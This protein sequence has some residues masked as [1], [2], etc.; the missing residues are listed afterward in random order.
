M[1]SQLARSTGSL[2]ASEAALRETMPLTCEICDNSRYLAS[3]MHCKHTLKMCQG[4]NQT[5]AIHNT[6]DSC[7]HGSYNLVEEKQANKHTIT[8]KEYTPF[9]K[10]I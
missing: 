2:W 1:C 4:L 5:L 3:E 9:Q 6:H 10:T 7:Q 8:S